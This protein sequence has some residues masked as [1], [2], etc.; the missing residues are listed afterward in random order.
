MWQADSFRPAIVSA[1]R[2]GEA[3]S[4][5][6]GRP[7]SWR[8]SEPESGEPGPSWYEFARSYAAAKWPY[9]APDQR[10]GIA[11]ALI[12]ATEVLTCPTMGSQRS[13][14]CAGHYVSGRL[15]LWPLVPSNLW[16]ILRLRLIGRS[17]TR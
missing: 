5:E 4:I 3:F 13:T 11:E 8:R 1:A 10:H 2:K 6:T 17:G 14:C 12:D 15:A 16:L 9:V 7:A